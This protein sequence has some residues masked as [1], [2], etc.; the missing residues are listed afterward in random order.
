MQRTDQAERFLEHMAS[1]PLTWENVFRSPQYNGKVHKEVVDLLLCLRNKG[2]FLSLKCQQD[3]FKRTGDQLARWVRK[4]SANAL[5]QLRGGIKTS[6]SRNFWCMHHRRGEVSFCA[7]QI[8][9]IR[10]VVIVETLETVTLDQDTPLEIDTVPVSYF[11]LNDFL[12]LLDQLRTINDLVL[13]L[14]ARQSLCMELQRTVGI[15][16]LLFKYYLLHRGSPPETPSLLHVRDEVR[17][18]RHEIDRLIHVRRELSSQA[19]PIE[20]LSDRLAT[21]LESYE[22]GLDEHLVRR[23]DPSTRRRNYLLMQDELCDLSLDERRKLG[24]Q[25]DGAVEMVKQARSTQPMVYQVAHLDSKPDFLYIFS[26]AKGVSRNEILNWCDGLLHGGLSYFKKTRG[27]V[28]N[29]MLDRDGCEA[30]MIPSFQD[31]PRAKLL[32]DELFS[33]L[34]MY[35]TEID[36]I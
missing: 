27:L 18:H 6:K 4:S 1:V 14:T 34:R 19:E 11:S 33:H 24:S 8:D 32:G 30:M 29:Y 21:R 9:D 25:F 15:D 2:V 35:S 28:V 10:A 7:N 5:S 26:A 16:K 13:Y 12:N 23:F 31:T 36:R 22:D 17:Q 20:I 3:P